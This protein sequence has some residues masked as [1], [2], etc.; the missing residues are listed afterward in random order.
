[1]KLISEYVHYIN[2]DEIHIISDNYSYLSLIIF[3]KL[4]N[5]KC[6]SSEIQLCP[7]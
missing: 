1:M 2:C 4:H 5:V 3:D 6:V 7:R